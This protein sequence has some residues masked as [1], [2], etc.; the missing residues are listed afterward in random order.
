MKSDRVASWF[1]DAGKSVDSVIAGIDKDLQP[2]SFVFPE[3]I[4]VEAETEVVRDIKTVHNVAAY[5]PGSTN[6]YVIIGAH[7]DHLGLG[8]QHW[9]ESGV[10]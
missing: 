3:T 10:R 1:N 7:Y 4:Q 2:R 8:G 6:E 9:R 5:L